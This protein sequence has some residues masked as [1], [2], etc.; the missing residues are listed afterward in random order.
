MQVAAILLMYF[1]ILAAKSSS[2]CGWLV[3]KLLIDS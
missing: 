1:W 2:P 3:L